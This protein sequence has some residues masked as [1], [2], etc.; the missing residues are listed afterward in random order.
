MV[1][2]RVASGD[3]QRFKVAAAAAGVTVSAY[4][5]GLISAG[6]LCQDGGC[7]WHERAAGYLEQ[8]GGQGDGDAGWAG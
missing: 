6:L 7:P 8:L 5:R 4:L 3:A 1:H 2:L